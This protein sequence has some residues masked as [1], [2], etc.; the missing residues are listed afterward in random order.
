MS[1][2]LYIHAR[3]EPTFGGFLGGG[4]VKRGGFVLGEGEWLAEAMKRNVTCGV[5][6]IRLAEGRGWLPVRR[7]SEGL[8][9]R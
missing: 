3:E 5:G 1:L 7:G 4:F 2:Y 9:G 8:C 6:F